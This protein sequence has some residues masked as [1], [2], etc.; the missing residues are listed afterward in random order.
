MLVFFIKLQ[1][2]VCDLNALVGFLF[3]Q[4]KTHHVAVTKKTSKCFWRRTSVHGTAITQIAVIINRL[5]AAEPTIVFLNRLM[6]AAL[7]QVL[8]L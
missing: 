8:S 2:T 5:K 7:K 4:P 6:F 1:E 3:N